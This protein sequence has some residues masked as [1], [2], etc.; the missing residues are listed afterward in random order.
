MDVSI[1]PGSLLGGLLLVL[2]LEHGELV[3]EILLTDPHGV[4]PHVCILINTSKQ[5]LGRNERTS[6]H[7]DDGQSL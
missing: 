1:S 3:G 4:A 6:D 2:L 5:Q 7:K